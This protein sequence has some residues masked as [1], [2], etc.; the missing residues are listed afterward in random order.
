MTE[1]RAGT[2]VDKCPSFPVAEMRL[3]ECDISGSAAITRTVQQPGPSSADVP[4]PGMRSFSGRLDK[5]FVSARLQRWTPLLQRQKFK[6]DEQ[7]GGRVRPTR[8]TG[9]G[10][11]MAAETCP[12]VDSAHLRPAPGYSVRFKPVP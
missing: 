1:A 5:V 11:L 6:R 4:Q 12:H 10:Q 3:G 7:S 9:F 2:L 8:G